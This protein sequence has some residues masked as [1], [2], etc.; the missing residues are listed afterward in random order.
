MEKVREYFTKAESVGLSKNYPTWPGVKVTFKEY[1]ESV[2]AYHP[3]GI[4]EYFYPG[5]KL[6]NHNELS[7]VYSMYCVDMKRLLKY[8]K[9]DE[10]LRD[11]L[12]GKIPWDIEVTL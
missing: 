11:M 9:K 1:A 4:R 3:E 6:L 2:C 8:A 10:Y 5:L 12:N 7:N